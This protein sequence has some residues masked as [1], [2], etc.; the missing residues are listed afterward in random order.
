M[1]ELPSG[2]VTFLFSDVDGSTRL[3]TEL[4]P[5]EYERALAEHRDVLRRAFAAYGGVEVDTQGDAF[6]VAFPRAD[7]ALA[8]AADL[9]AALDGG[10]V[11]VR[12]GVHTGEPLLGDQGYVGLDVHRA[13]R[14]A[15]AGHGGQVL[16][17]QTTRDLVPQADLRDLGEHR[18]KDLTVP[19]RLFQLGGAEFPA[20]RSLNR[21]NLPIAAGP[22]LGREGELAEVLRMIDDGARLVTL[23]GPGGSGKTRL[24]LQVAAELVERFPDGVFFVGLAQLRDRDLVLGAIAESTGLSSTDDVMA[25][26]AGRRMLLVLDNAEHLELADQVAGLLDAGRRLV[27]VVTTRVPLHLSAE[28]EVAVEPLAASAAVELFVARARAVG[29]RVTPD[30]TIRTICLRLDCLPLAVELAAA[31]VKSLSS[32]ALLQR[33][34]RVLT[35]LAGGTRDAPERQQTMRAAIAWS[36]DLLDEPERAA[37]RRLSVF[38]GTLALDAALV[39]AGVELDVLMSLVD[40]SM[41]KPI[42]DARF[43]M[44]ETLREFARER[45]DDAGETEEFA[46]RHA[47]YYLERLEEIDPVLRGPRTPEFLAWYGDEEDNLRALVDRLATAAPQ[48]AA[49]AAVLLC[50]YWTARGAIV[51]GRQRL[52]DLLALD[53]PD[54]SRAALLQRLGDIDFRL[55]RI[56]ESESATKAAIELAGSAGDRRVHASALLDLG[57]LEHKRG[58]SG[59]AVELARRALDEVRAV[60]HAHDSLR[61]TEQLAVFLRGAGRE[62]EARA[63]FAEAIDG[64]R[65]VGDGSNEAIALTNLA[66]LEFHAG[67]F[68]SA[69]V[70]YAAAER[71]VAATGHVTARCSALNGAAR[72]HL[73]LGRLADARS[74][75]LE[76]L[77]LASESGAVMEIA[78]AIGGVALAS[79]DEAASPAARLRGAV[80]ELRRSTG[81]GSDPREEEFERLHEDRIRGLLGEDVFAREQRAGSTLPLED[82][83]GLA[84]QLAASG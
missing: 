26:L 44:L 18:L 40:K 6:F 53:L 22:L 59:E 24:S 35:L 43:F 9:T 32:A 60:G 15:A 62:E 83:I 1:A 57:W 39:V 70:M 4:G 69:Y 81:L 5:A 37:F 28:R 19:E 36:H 41:L 75:W 47:R 17:S 20:L 12:V 46:M 27:V 16:V 74:T 77:S 58:R 55:G 65:R 33:L 66:V 63:A 71:I 56:D 84:R 42:G 11:A 21:T 64:F 72:C 30:E 52:N 31:R 10:P 54:G 38:R 8:A 25:A 82:A 13:A 76:V 14:I 23:T 45:L 29:T 78:Y 50:T 2:T 48:Q 80:W 79:A 61:M 73:A 3:L 7:G 51:E 49:R 34:D 68:E 67:D